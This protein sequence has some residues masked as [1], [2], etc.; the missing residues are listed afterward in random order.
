MKHSTIY[1]FLSG[2]SSAL[3]LGS[4]AVKDLPPVVSAGLFILTAA[5]A[6]L[7]AGLGV[8]ALDKEAGQ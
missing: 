5:T 8:V 4:I 7:L 3:A 1:F 2:F 6:V